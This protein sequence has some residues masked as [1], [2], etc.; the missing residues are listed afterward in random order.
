M[1]KLQ[2]WDTAG[3]DRYRAI[4]SSYYRGASG[5]LLVYDITKKKSFENIE[6]WL[7]ELRTHGQE[8]MTLMLIGNKTDLAKMREVQTEDA[9]NYAERE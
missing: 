7:T 5:A 9:A 8:N 6:R 4:A 1:F 2:I 3:Q